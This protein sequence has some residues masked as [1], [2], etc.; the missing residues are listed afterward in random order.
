MSFIANQLSNNLLKT[1]SK[2]FFYGI[3]KDL[4]TAACANCFDWK[5]V[6]IERSAVYTD[7]ECRQEN[8]QIE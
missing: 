7:S 3:K 5:E 1:V 6:V 4:T 2:S 8:A